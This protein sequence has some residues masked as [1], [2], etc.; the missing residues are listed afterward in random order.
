M[1][2]SRAL[3]SLLQRTQ[4]LQILEE[5]LNYFITFQNHQ[6][7]VTNIT[8]SVNKIIALN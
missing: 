3:S 6:W 7:Q 5:L 8:Q 2:S 1:A 4:L